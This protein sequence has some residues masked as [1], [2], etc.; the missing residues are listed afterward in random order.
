MRVVLLSLAR[1]WVGSQGP[2]LK[3][4]ATS[5]LRARKEKRPASDVHEGLITAMEM[6]R[7]K[8]HIRGFATIGPVVPCQL[9]H[10]AAFK[11]WNFL[12]THQHEALRRNAAVGSYAANWP[13]RCWPYLVS[14]SDPFDA[15]ERSDLVLEVDLPNGQ[16]GFWFEIEMRGTEN[17]SSAFVMHRG[18][19]ARKE[20]TEALQII[21]QASG[22]SMSRHFHSKGIEC[23]CHPHYFEKDATKTDKAKRDEAPAGGAKKD[24]AKRA[25]MDDSPTTASGSGAAAGATAAGTPADARA[26]TKPAKT[27][28]GVWSA[29]PLITFFSRFARTD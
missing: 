25:K 4:S 6:L 10:V 9:V 2:M 15:Q 21:R 26:A 14:G 20:I 12:T 16:R 29:G 28:S 3:I 7:T 19:D 17:Y 23:Y 22:I 5:H 13:T 1:S 24:D 27:R 11:C 18:G 8:G